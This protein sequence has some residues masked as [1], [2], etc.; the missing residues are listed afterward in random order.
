MAEGGSIRSSTRRKTVNTMDTAGFMAGVRSLTTQELAKKRQKCG[1]CVKCGISTHKIKKYG[2]INKKV[3]LTI[4]GKVDNGRCTRCRPK[5]GD[6]FAAE[7]VC[8]ITK[9]EIDDASHYPDNERKIY[10]PSGVLLAADGDESK[11]GNDDGSI[12]VTENGR[13]PVDN[14]S[15]ASLPMKS[16]I[17]SEKAQVQ[18]KG[19]DKKGDKKYDASLLK[20]PLKS[21]IISKKAQVQKKGADNKGKKKYD[22]KYDASLLKTPLKSA[23]ISKKAQVQKKG[24]DNKGKKKYDEKYDASLLKTP[25]KSAIISKKA[26]VQKKGADKKGDKKNDKDKYVRTRRTHANPKSRIPAKVVRKSSARSEVKAML[27]EF[28]PKEIVTFMRESFES[29]DMQIYALQVLHEQKLSTA[30]GAGNFTIGGGMELVVDLMDRYHRERAIWKEILLALHKILPKCLMAHS[31]F[32]TNEGYAY[33][34]DAIQFFISN[35]EL[36]ICCC[37]ISIFICTDKESANFMVECGAVAHLLDLLCYEKGSPESITKAAQ[38]LRGIFDVSEKSI[39]EFIADDG[40]RS[41]VTASVKDELNPELMK[42]LLSLVTVAWNNPKYCNAFVDENIVLRISAIMEMHRLDESFQVKACQALKALTETGSS[43]IAE[44]CLNHIITALQN[45]AHSESLTVG[46]VETI[47][48]IL[49]SDSSCAI[50]VRDCNPDVFELIS[51]AAELYPSCQKM[52]NIILC[53]IG[54]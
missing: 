42:A 17:I 50:K 30:D 39:K 13:D 47:Y 44:F 16:G 41:V 15:D 28:S 34:L 45:H 4:R 21:A 18:K 25:L 7:G 48:Y 29:Q 9:I 38:A 6:E 23:I 24:A 32:L 52:A 31:V 51:S 43:E 3:A 19:A 46:V 1:N 8:I 12:S 27:K 20:T 33:V 22:E 26:Q 36:A 5:A 49:R 40:P 35:D 14:K 10:S 54:A 53:K 2:F 11:N 37:D